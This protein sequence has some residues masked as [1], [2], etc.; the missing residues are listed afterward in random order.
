MIYTWMF[1]SS[2]EI[3]WAISCQLRDSLPV[4]RGQLATSHLSQD[5][6][7]LGPFLLRTPGWLRPGK[8]SIFNRVW[9]WCPNFWGFKWNTSPCNKM[10]Q[11]SV[12]DSKYPLNSWVMWN[13]GTSIPS[14]VQPTACG[15]GCGS[16]IWVRWAWIKKWVRT[17]WNKMAVSWK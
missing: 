14:P 8:W 3:R 4:I 17:K 12:G 1:I 2:R 5:L 10:K 7:C 15:D 13:I 16:I 9:D 11:V 6:P